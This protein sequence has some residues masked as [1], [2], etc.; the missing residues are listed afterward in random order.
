MSG[1]HVVT[2]PNAVRVFCGYR[3]VHI[4]GGEGEFRRLLGD[5]FMPGTPYMLRPLGLHAYAAAVFDED[6]TRD[7]PH[8]TGLIAYPSQAAYRTI[9]SRNLRGRL[10]TSTH[11]AVYDQS[12]TDGTRRSSGQ[13]A[14]KFT[15][16]LDHAARTV[17]MVD[18]SSDLQRGSL[19]VHLGAP[20]D[21]NRAGDQFRRDVRTALPA[22]RDAV[23]KHGFSQAFVTMQDRYYV[24]W[25]HSEEDVDADPVDDWLATSTRLAKL[26]A[27]RVLFLE[28]SPLVMIDR[29]SAFN[30]VFER[31][32]AADLA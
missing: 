7:T 32:P 11:A 13:F 3:N 18:E 28:D 5:T 4:A 15:D 10:Y 27:E 8:E 30:F 17:Y 2:P 22:F 14:E 31:S 6:I 29:P 12:V 19:T 9:R 23:R 25:L 1:E 26:E 20:T 24:A 21:T 16:A